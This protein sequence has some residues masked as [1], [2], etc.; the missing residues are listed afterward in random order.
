MMQSRL[1]LLFGSGWEEK[2][3]IVK[4]VNVSL[5]YWVISQVFQ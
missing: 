1:N 5:G 3:V 2:H 4:Y